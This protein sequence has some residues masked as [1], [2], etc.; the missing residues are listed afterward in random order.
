M[1]PCYDYNCRDCD[2]TFEVKHSMNEKPKVKCPKCKSGKTAK[3]FPIVGMITQS[4]RHVDMGRAIDQVKRNVEMQQRLKTEMG[5]EK[6]NPIGRS[7]MK[8]VYDDAMAQ[9]TQIRES[10]AEQ[11]EV[12]GKETAIKQREWTRKA[13]LRTPQRSKERAEKKAAEAASK[14]AIRL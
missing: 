4:S 7:S 5:I 3:C 14:R 10:M 1:A 12:R 8:Q 6:I 2:S 13:L 11:A 9:K